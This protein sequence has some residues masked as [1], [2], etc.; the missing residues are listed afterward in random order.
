MMEFAT[1]LLEASIAAVILALGLRIS[2]A[3]S[4]FMVC[5][6]R[7]LLRA[8]IT[9]EVL[10]PLLVISVLTAL[11][12]P[13]PAVMGTTLLAVSPG[14]PLLVQRELNAGSRSELVVSSSAL[15]ALLSIVTIPCWLT[16]VSWLFINDASV[17][18]VAVMRLVGVL[19]LLPLSVGILLRRLAPELMT[20]ASGF[21]L[22]VADALLV[23]ALLSMLGDVLP[24]VRRL[25]VGYGVTLT[26]LCTVT[27][28]L[29]HFLGGPDARDR[30]TLALMC[31]ARH[32][33]LALL[34]SR[35]NFDDH[36]ALAAV[37]SSFLIGTLVTFPYLYWRWQQGQFGWWKRD[38]PPLEA[39][40]ESA[41]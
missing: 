10:V 41:T 24:M 2:P 29:G 32:P 11:H 8:L 35:C 39:T 28:F 19:F 40:V 12:M 26:V 14:M 16:V 6:P 33:G 1:L 23:V 15:S 38:D 22:I 27:T 9:M 3:V 20:R 5:Q 30:S 36:L 25:G 18:P 31:A 21:V 37:V 4:R 7:V 34:I 17:D 13:A